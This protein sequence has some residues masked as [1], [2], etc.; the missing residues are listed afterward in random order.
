VNARSP[1]AEAAR[2]RFYLDATSCRIARV[3][4]AALFENRRKPRGSASRLSP[5]KHISYQRG[6]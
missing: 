4:E 6:M 5:I 1:I 3:S 2:F